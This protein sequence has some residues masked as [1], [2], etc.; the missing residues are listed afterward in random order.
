MCQGLGEGSLGLRPGAAGGTIRTRSWAS[1]KG[2]GVG[3]MGEAGPRNH[4]LGGS[5]GEGWCSHL[6]QAH[7]P[8][9]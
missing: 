9:Q 8:L 6:Q 1:W 7:T 5:P 3:W 2:S 4:S